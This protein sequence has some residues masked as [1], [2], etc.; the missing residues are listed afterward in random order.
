[1]WENLKE[2]NVAKMLD[3][4]GIIF[5]EHEPNVWK[6]LNETDVINP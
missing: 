4:Y 5:L 3:V 1:V 6:K 2:T